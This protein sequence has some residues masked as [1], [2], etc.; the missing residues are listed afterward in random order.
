MDGLALLCTLH[1]DGPA[2]LKRLRGVGCSNLFELLERPVTDLAHALDVA[3]AAA[4]RLLREARL[5]AERVGPDLEAEDAPAGIAPP[6]VGAE[7]LALEVA[8]A[9]NPLDRNDRAL[10]ERIVREGRSAAEPNGPRPAPAASPLPPLAAPLAPLERVGLELGVDG[11]SVQTEPGLE[12]GGPSQASLPGPGPHQSQ[13]AAPDHAPPVDRRAFANEPDGI[14]AVTPC[15]APTAAAQAVDDG[16]ALLALDGVDAELA[17]E[18]A[19]LGF[20]TPAA[21]ADADSLLLRRELGITYAQVKRLVFLAKRAAPASMSPAT[22]IAASGLATSGLAASGLAASGLAASATRPAPAA[23]SEPAPLRTIE[24]PRRAEGHRPAAP[25]APAPAG[26][27]AA[28]ERPTASAAPAPR[29]EPEPLRPGTWRIQ[30]RTE[31]LPPQVEA[32]RDSDAA[33]RLTPAPVVGVAPL[34]APV[35][36]VRPRFWE[37]RPHLGTAAPAETDPTQGVVV[38]PSEVHRPRR[39]WEARR[40]TAQAQGA[41]EHTSGDRKV[42]SA[43]AHATPPLAVAPQPAVP[44]ASAAAHAAPHAG[45]NAA[46]GTTLGWNFEIP[47]P[48]LPSPADEPPQ[49]RTWR[50]LEADESSAGPFA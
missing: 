35:E 24:I 15:P 46:A 4:R 29:P 8:P 50:P 23:G 20:G 9:T 21:L 7:P 36:P 28:D 6:Q 34:A 5:L 19:A 11:A 18:L 43:A 37:P 27:T 38:D 1:A 30:P 16:R 42:A 40:A 25:P 47:R 10:L 33:A 39:F 31:P 44:P 49:R 48:E 32:D 3:P 41:L 2:T 12:V 26:W 17:R 13:A 14:V 45:A 22:G